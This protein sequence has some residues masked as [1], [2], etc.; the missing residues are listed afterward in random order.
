MLEEYTRGVGGG[1]GKKPTGKPLD[2]LCIVL[3]KLLCFSHGLISRLQVLE[4]GSP[5]Y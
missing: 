1:G 2:R 5:F 4:A 3:Q